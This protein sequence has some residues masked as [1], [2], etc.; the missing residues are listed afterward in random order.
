MIRLMFGMSAT[1]IPEEPDELGGVLQRAAEH[2]KA[3]RPHIAR[4]V[5]AGAQAPVVLY[6]PTWDASRPTSTTEDRRW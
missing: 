2:P 5:Q 1:Q 3:L 4:V 6:G